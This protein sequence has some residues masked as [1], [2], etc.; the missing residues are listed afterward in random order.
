YNQEYKKGFIATRDAREISIKLDFKG[1]E[2]LYHLTLATF[3]GR[4][5]MYNYQIQLARNLSLKENSQLS[6]YYTELNIPIGYPPKTDQLLLDKLTPILH[7]FEQ[8]DDKEIQLALIH[9]MGSSYYRLGRLNKLKTIFKK[10]AELSRDLYQLYPEFL[11]K[12]R[13]KLR[14]DSEG[15]TEESKKIEQELIELLSK[16]NDS[17]ENGFI[18][19]VQANYYN[20]TGQYA[21][22][23]DYYLKSADAFESADDL[24]MLGE[25]YDKLGY[26]YETLEM[27]GKAAEIYEKYISLF[28]KTNDNVRLHNAYNRPVY[29]LFELKRYDDARNYMALAL[30]GSNE[31]G[32]PLLQAK[33]NSLEGQILLDKGEYSKAITYLQKTYEDYSSIDDQKQIAKH[34]ISF[35]LLYMAECYQ[36]MGDMKSAIKY[37]LECLERENGL[38]HKRTIIKSKISF[39]ISEIYIEMEQPEKAFDFLKMYQRIV[40]ESNKTE[41]ANKVAEAEIRSIIDK[42]EKQIDLLER[43]RIQKIQESKNQRLWIFSITGALLS[44]L[45]LSLVLY[46]NNKNKQKANAQL[47]EQKEEI[48]VTLEKLEETQ[49]QLIQSEKMAS[50]GEPTAGIAHEIQ[51]PLNFVNNFSEVSKELADE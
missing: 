50:L 5:E 41:N 10:I 39:L 31:Q 16:G 17:N 12:T 34:T 40:V 21:L 28:K 42:S 51:N 4:G 13:L 7:F 33:S 43:E 46:R 20:S 37:A 26:A 8:L 44:A 24:S 2:V 32:R 11:A 19:F 15:N 1:G 25:I 49:S 27:Q 45:I 22:A 29:P 47:K 48:Q 23:I 6:E 9:K 35:T 14:F 38:N 36:K 18:N 3:F 30:Q